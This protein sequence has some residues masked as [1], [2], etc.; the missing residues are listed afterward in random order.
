MIRFTTPLKAR[1]GFSTVM[2]VL[3][4]VIFFRVGATDPSVPKNFQ[5]HFGG[6]MIILMS[7]MFGTAL[8]SLMQF[9]VEHQ[10]FY[11]STLPD[12]TMWYLTFAQD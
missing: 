10:F 6:L 1:Y 12:I 5:S 8:P 2:S 11:A 9:P 3:I 4:G 7:N